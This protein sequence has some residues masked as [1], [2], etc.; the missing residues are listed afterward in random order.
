MAYIVYR[1]ETNRNTIIFN[2]DEINTKIFKCEINGCA[3]THSILA[4]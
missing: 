3:I 4:K 1:Q 2:H